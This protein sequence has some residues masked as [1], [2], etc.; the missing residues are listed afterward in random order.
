MSTYS[1]DLRITLIATGDQAGTW[2]ATTNTNLGTVIEDAISGYVTVS[3][4]S[5]NQAFTAFDGAADEARNAM[6]R[7]TTTTVAP[8]NVYAPPSSKQYIIWNNSGQAATIYNSTVLGNTTAAGTGVTIANGDRV[9]VFSNGTN[10][11]D[12]KASGVTGTVAIANGGT[13]QTTANAGF[14]ALAPSQTGNSGRYLKTDGTNTA[15]DAIDI[16]T[17]DISGTLAI[18]NGGTGGSNQADARSNLGLG[19]IATQNASSV[20]ITGGS[21]TGITDL[22]IADGGTGAST[23]AGARSNL[24]LGSMATQNANNVSITGG[25]VTGITDLAIADGGTG[26]STANGAFNALAPSQTG[27]AGR[28][29]KTDGTN[30]SWDALDI[31]TADISGVL[32]PANGGTGVANNNAATLT[33]SGNHALTLTTSAVT[34][35]VLPTAGTLATLAGTETLTNKTINGTSNT[36]TNVSLSTGVTGTLPVANG[37]TGGTNQADARSGLGLGSI[38]TQNA[39]SVSITGGSATNL[40]SMSTSSATI[41][42]GTITGITDL[43]V[44]DGGT[45]ASDATG[46]RNN[47]GLGSMATQNSNSVS[48][49]GGTISSLVSFSTT[50]AT[51][52]GGAISG[53]SLTLVTDNTNNPLSQGQLIYNGTEGSLVFGRALG[54]VVVVTTTTTQTLTNKTL[55][56][57]VLT[58]PTLGTPASGTL[59]NCTGLPIDGGTTGTLPVLRGGTGVTTSTGSGSNVLSTSPALSGTPTAPTAALGTNTTQLATTAFVQTAVRALYPV[60]SIYINATVSTNPA[61]LLGF[62]TWVAFGAGRVPVG[63]NASDPL[64][65]AAEETGGSKDAIVVSHTHTATTSLTD[66]G[67]VHTANMSIATGNATPTDVFGHGTGAQVDTGTTNSSTTGITATTTVASSGSSGTNANLQPYITVYMWKRTA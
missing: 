67:H 59:T 45:G 54:S 33:R 60:G 41:T 63:F 35:L 3:V 46:A 55:T 2:G 9:V 16:S 39:N 19:S 7:L 52:T 42:G 8:F 57:P 14:N 62:G 51:I 65:D 27:Q 48:I 38:A 37:G 44:A 50:S 30:T 31:S 34:S 10:F 21:I 32:P 29:L 1:P 66:P 58:S 12:I 28:Y 24:E 4:T 23:A 43:A 40:T 6:I 47:L 25:S 26:Q 11:Y 61:T 20:S 22:A 49:S 13:G 64:F 17:A 36:I 53:T 56:S 18:A 5:A 15:W